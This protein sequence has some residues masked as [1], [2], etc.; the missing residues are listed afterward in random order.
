MKVPHTCFVIPL[1]H[2][3]T[4]TTDFQRQIILQ[5]KK[6]S[7]SSLILYHAYAPRQ[8]WKSLLSRAFWK[9][10]RSQMSEAKKTGQLDFFPLHLLPFER[11]KTV[12][13][14]N[15]KISFLMAIFLGWLCFKPDT[16]IYWIFHPRYYSAMALSRNILDDKVRVIYDC[17]DYLSFN[18]PVEEK[19]VRETENKLLEEA[20]LVSV[21]S[22][23]LLNKFKKVAT[24]IKQF[25]PGFRSDDF[26]NETFSLPKKSKTTLMFVGGINYRTNFS[27]VNQLA[28]RNP[29]WQIHLIGPIY[30][31]EEGN[32]EQIHK[33]LQAILKL[34]NVTHTHYVEPSKLPAYYQQ[35]DIGIIPYDL[36]VPLNMYCNPMKILEYFYFGVPVVSTPIPALKDTISPFIA[37]GA[38]VS[39]W[40]RIITTFLSHPPTKTDQQQMRNIAL[41]NS[42]EKKFNLIVEDINAMDSDD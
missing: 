15:Q 37:S 13:A 33:E 32:T 20:D 7:H 39:E 42:W 19:I 40:E 35:A 6:R 25:P 3:L 4:R 29:S 24:L 23:T 17:V 18:N 5:V 36:N 9:Q 31:D 41:E 34:S 22:S 11:I 27:F 38:T 2:Q 21:N 14:I 26:S 30:E 16:F 1:D 28:K 10:L 12:Y 8:S